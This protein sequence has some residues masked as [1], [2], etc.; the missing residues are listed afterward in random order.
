MNGR[1]QCLQIKY[2]VVKIHNMYVIR[3]ARKIYAD[4]DMAVT[5]LDIFNA[6]ISP[7]SLS[8]LV[9]TKVINMGIS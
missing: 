8:V 9:C 4:T 6:L 5:R 3:K 1:F 7:L 2:T